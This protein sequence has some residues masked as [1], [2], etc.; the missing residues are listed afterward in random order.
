MVKDPSP[1][2]SEK[3]NVSTNN[4]REVIHILVVCEGHHSNRL[5]KKLGT[6][7]VDWRIS[8]YGFQMPFFKQP[9]DTIENFF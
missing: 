7:L 2:L 4:L 1:L 5:D 6:L 3:H 8:K 9:T